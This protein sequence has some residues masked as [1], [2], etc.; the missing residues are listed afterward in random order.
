MMSIR[1]T[2]SIT[3]SVTSV[4]YLRQQV[5]ILFSQLMCEQ[6]MAER[7]DLSEADEGQIVMVRNQG[8]SI[9]KSAAQK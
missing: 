8:Q 2:I 5:N 9:T 3:V 6:Q 7:K 4:E 1:Q